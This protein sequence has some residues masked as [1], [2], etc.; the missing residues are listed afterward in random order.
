[1]PV[2]KVKAKSSKKS[3]KADLVIKGKKK[4][5]FFPD[6]AE[7]FV[8]PLE[9]DV[10]FR[11]DRMKYVR[12]LIPQEGCVFCRAAQ[13]KKPDFET[14]NVYQTK[15]SMVVL[16][17][18]P[19]NSGHVLIIPRRHCGDLQNLSAEEYHDLMD[20]LRKTMGALTEVYKPSGMN[21]GLNHG[22]AAGAGIP[23]HLHF[24]VIPRW[25]GDVNF[26]PLIAET[27]VLVESLEQTF[28]RLT[29]YFKTK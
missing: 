20:L 2:K 26:F 14:L 23:E 8:W 28:E 6:E 9:R 22:A 1:M 13:S 29:L 5:D 11:P 15:H 4:K 17:K 25:S 3:V 24:H 27:K 12:R 21:V 19:Y 18:F 7:G 10:L 16:N